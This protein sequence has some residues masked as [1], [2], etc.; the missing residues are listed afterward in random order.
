[1]WGISFHISTSVV[2][3]QFIAGQWIVQIG[4]FAGLALISFFITQQRIQ[5]SVVKIKKMTTILGYLLLIST[6]TF[7]FVERYTLAPMAFVAVPMSVYMA[8]WFQ[9]IRKFIF[10]EFLHILLLGMTFYFQY[11]KYIL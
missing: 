7:A 10:A 11:A 6:L 9:G 8:Y 1:L 5:F 3:E 2:T 4:V